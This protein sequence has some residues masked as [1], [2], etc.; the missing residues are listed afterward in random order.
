MAL[1][2]IYDWAAREDEGTLGDWNTRKKKKNRPN[3]STTSPVWQE[4]NQ[5]SASHLKNQ[6]DTPRDITTSW[7]HI[8]QSRS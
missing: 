7:Q 4:A 1:E 2:E 6:Q 3:E 8:Y 5:A